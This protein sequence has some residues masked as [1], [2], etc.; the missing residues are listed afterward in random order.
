MHGLK[1]EVSVGCVGVGCGQVSAQL[2]IHSSVPMTPHPGQK[3][4]LIFE[5][6][7]LYILRKFQIQL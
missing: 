6:K 5:T 7:Q 1:A 3:K 2:S 4:T